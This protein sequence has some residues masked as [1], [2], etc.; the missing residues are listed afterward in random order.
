MGRV[1]SCGMQAAARAVNS[2]L[3]SALVH[4]QQCGLLLLMHKFCGVAASLGV[5]VALQ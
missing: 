5:S 3:T 2:R 4:T 1:L